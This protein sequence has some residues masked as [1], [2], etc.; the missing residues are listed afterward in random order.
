MST[1]TN[2]TLKGMDSQEHLPRTPSCVF[3]QRRRE[4]MYHGSRGG[5][6]RHMRPGVTEYKRLSVLDTVI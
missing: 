6:P 5:W 2:H 4:R 3:A 1:T